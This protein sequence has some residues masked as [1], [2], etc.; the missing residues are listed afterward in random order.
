MIIFWSTKQQTTTL[1]TLQFTLNKLLYYL[2]IFFYIF[3]YSTMEQQAN[4][5]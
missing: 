3:I 4:S 5:K 2:F 1:A